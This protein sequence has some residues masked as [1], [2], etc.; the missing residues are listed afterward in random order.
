MILEE[1]AA[2]IKLAMLTNY[3][4]E[5][6]CICDFSSGGLDVRLP[7]TIQSLLRD[8]RYRLFRF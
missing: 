7:R 2:L 4:N 5:I 6:I 8:H 3:E 1:V